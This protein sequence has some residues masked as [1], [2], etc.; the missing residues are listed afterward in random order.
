MKKIVCLFVLGLSFLMIFSCSKES[1]KNILKETKRDERSN[2]KIVVLKQKVKNRRYSSSIMKKVVDID[3]SKQKEKNMIYSPEK[4]LPDNKGNLYIIDLLNEKYIFHKLIPISK[5]YDK[6][7]HI[8]FSPPQGQGP[9]DVSRMLD[10]K[11]YDNKFYISDMGTQSIKIF[12][13]NGKYL[14]SIVIFANGKKHFGKFSFLKDKLIVEN[15]FYFADG[16]KFAMCD[17]QGHLIE[18]FG[19]HIDGRNKDNGIYHDNY[20]SRGFGENEYYY[21]P[22]Y[23]GFVTKYKNDKVVFTKETI[24]GLQNVIAIKRKT[25]FGI[26]RKIIKKSEAVLDYYIFGNYI[27]IKSKNSKYDKSVWDIYTLDNFDYLLTI[28][29]KPDSYVVA[30]YKN[31][32][33]SAYESKLLIYDI[34][35]LLNELKKYNKI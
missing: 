25:K 4:L 2:N 12:D 13:L 6:F 3:F 10:V 28:S 17:P 18:L 1:K 24:D 34:T 9:G 21:L 14:K 8:V 15:Y 35:D 27:L 29:D 30:I 33:I 23:L 22:F 7:N 20:L 31:R 19:S 32:L 16:E 26:L 5:K 11:I